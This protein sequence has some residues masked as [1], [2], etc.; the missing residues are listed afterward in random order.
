MNNYTSK[1]LVFCLVAFASLS[2]VGCDFFE[3]LTGD[4]EPGSAGE[5]LFPVRIDGD[6]GYV[7]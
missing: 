6:W 5:A 4:D 1:F 7:K 3:D 2:L